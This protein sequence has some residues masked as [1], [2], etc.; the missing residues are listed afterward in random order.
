MKRTTKE[1]IRLLF[2]KLWEQYAVRVPYTLQYADLVA[3]KGRKVVI[4]HIA[5]RTFNAHTGEQPEGIR[6]IKHILNFLGYVPVSK[7]KFPKKKLNSTHFEHP[8]ETLPKIFVTQLEVNDLPDWAQNIVNEAVHNTFYLLNDKS[9]EL[10]AILKENESLPVEAADYLVNDLVQY[11]RRPWNIPL[12]D[13]VLKM[14]DISQFGAWVLIHGN[15]VN[16]FAAL[17]NSQDVKEWANLETTTNALVAAGIPVNENIEG[18]PGGK[19]RQTATK[20]TKEEVDVKGEDGFETMV[21]TYAYFEFIERNYIEMDGS[22]K[23][24]SGFLAG[25]E[26]LLFDLTETH[27]N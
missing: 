12:K 18:E 2:E 19:L 25:H 4:D 5:F 11:F 24:F 15:S 22:Q 7:Y 8:D 6:A 9:L 1:I 14:N 23:L 13:E 26:N 16:H 27:E 20:A 3:E 21:W 10:L 17:V